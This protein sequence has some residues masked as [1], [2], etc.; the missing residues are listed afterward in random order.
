MELPPPKHQDD[1]GGKE[2]QLRHPQA[3]RT[4]YPCFK[5]Q[6][7]L[8]ELLVLLYAANAVAVGSR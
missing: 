8:I 2:P 3:T 4:G 5:P 7:V 1:V 6:A